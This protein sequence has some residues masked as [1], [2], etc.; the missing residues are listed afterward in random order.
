VFLC[1]VL[2]AVLLEDGLLQ[3]SFGFGLY[4]CIFRVVLAPWMLFLFVYFI[5]CGVGPV[6]SSLDWCLS[7]VICSDLML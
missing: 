4:V 7:F 1:R 3:L 2:G 5:M 6:S